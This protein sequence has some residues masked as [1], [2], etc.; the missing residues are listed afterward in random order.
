MAWQQELIKKLRQRRF[1]DKTSHV[2]KGEDI[3]PVL[4]IGCSS[5]PVPGADFVG[6]FLHCEF[7][8]PEMRERLKG[9]FVRCDVH[10]LPFCD[11]AFGFLH[12]SN[13]FEHVADPPKAFAELKRVSVHGFIECPNAFRERCII[14]PDNHSW[15]IS[16][17]DGE[18]QH[19]K[20]TQ[21]R[22][23]GIQILP[24]PLA[25][26]IKNNFRFFWK[27][28]MYTLDQILDVA[29]NKHRW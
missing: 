18:I 25:R 17:K 12:C 1:D 10:H 4:D 23:A 24:S 27:C 14:H 3:H 28:F 29:Y 16:W 11:N 2:P 5:F 8:M 21:I 19:V 26:V 15:I 20:P 22:I 6:D 9:K 7:D 13:V